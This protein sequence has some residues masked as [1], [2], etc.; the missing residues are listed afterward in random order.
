MPVTR[1][2][3]LGQ[4]AAGDDG[5][6]RAVLRELARRPIP[7]GTELVGLEQPMDLVGLLTEPERGRVVLVDA[8]L[9]APP[10]R[11]VVLPPE[12]LAGAGASPPSSHGLGAAWAIDLAL[13][14]S[15]G[16]TRDLDIVAV[17]IRAPARHKV[18]LSPAVRAAVPR[19][20]AQ[21]LALLAEPRG[22]ALGVLRPPV[23]PL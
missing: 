4:T 3:G 16:A 13:T 19:A 2:V 6:G 1:V 8:V 12:S 14:L 15:P 21:V 17:T 11:V 18:G 9:A 20:V 23:I 10:G 7:P 22:G 5:V